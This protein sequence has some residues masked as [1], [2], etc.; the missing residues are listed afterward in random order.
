MFSDKKMYRS[1][2]ELNEQNIVKSKNAHLHKSVPQYY[3]PAQAR[4][5][6]ARQ[7]SRL[8]S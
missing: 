6:E 1:V 2:E 8:K 7:H 4:H 3:G 5:I